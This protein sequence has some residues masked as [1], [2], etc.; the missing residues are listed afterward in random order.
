MICGYQTDIVSTLTLEIKK[1]VGKILYGDDFSNTFLADRIVLAEAA[2]QCAAAE[3]YS[4][5]ATGTTD[6]RFLPKMKS[7]TGRCKHC[8]TSTDSPPF[9]TV[10][11]A[12]PWTEG[13]VFVQGLEI[14][15]GGVS[16]A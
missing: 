5:A 11:A 7:G 1:N 12:H 16:L 3:K 10:N 14:C 13:A 6:T 15:Y 2:L 9:C 4:S 8:C